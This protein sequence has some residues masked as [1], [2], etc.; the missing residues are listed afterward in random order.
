MHAELLADR[1]NRVPLRRVLVLVLEHHAHSALFQLRRMPP[2][3]VGHD[4][5]LS[6]VGARN[7]PG[8]VQCCGSVTRWPGID[9]TFLK[10]TKDHLRPNRSGSD[11]VERY[12]PQALDKIPEPWNDRFRAQLL[13]SV[14]LMSEDD[15][16]ILEGWDA[17]RRVHPSSGYGFSNTAGLQSRRP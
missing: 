6:E 4:S 2:R 17:A 10:S 9:S 5:I 1:A 14:D 11:W 13:D 15:I 12:Y 8:E 16:A 7:F 3:L